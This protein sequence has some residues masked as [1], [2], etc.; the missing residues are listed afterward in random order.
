VT[1]VYGGRETCFQEDSAFPNSTNHSKRTI[2]LLETTS[3]VLQSAAEAVGRVTSE[4]DVWPERIQQLISTWTFGQLDDLNSRR[5]CRD[6]LRRLNA[7]RL[8]KK[9]RHSFFCDLLTSRAVTTLNR[10]GWCFFMIC[11]VRFSQQNGSSLIC[12]C[13]R[14]PAC[15]EF[16]LV[17]TVFM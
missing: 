10:T 13:A 11:C 5:D 15:C 1:Q 9:Y 8:W 12:L 2:S 14:R 7:Y 16:R 6:N 3:A 17:I 4:C